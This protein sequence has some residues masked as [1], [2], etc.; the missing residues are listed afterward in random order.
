MNRYRIYVLNPQERISDAQE[1]EYPDDQ[2]ALTAAAD[3]CGD[4]F[5]VEVWSGERLVDRLGGEFRL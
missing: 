2:A 5:A 1:G 3:L 4:R